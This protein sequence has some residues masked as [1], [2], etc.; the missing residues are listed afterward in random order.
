MVRK[1]RAVRLHRRA[2]ANAHT[3]DEWAAS[4]RQL[5]ALRGHDVWRAERDSKHFDGALLRAQLRRIRSARVGGRW[6]DLVEDV[7]EGLHRHL[8]ELTAP[9]LYGH[10]VGGTKYIVDEFFDEVQACIQ[11]LAQ[12]SLPETTDAERLHRFETAFQNFGRSAL[13]LSGGATLGFY[14]LGVARALWNNG[15]LPNIISGSSMGAMVAAAVC[16][17]TDNELAIFFDR[18]RD[19]DPKALA[20]LSL[21]EMIKHRALLDQELLRKAIFANFKDQTFADAYARTGRVLNITVSPT[22]ARQKPRVLNYRTAPRVLV[23]Q[24]CLA[25]SAVPGLFPPVTLMQRADSGE[26]CPYMPSETWMDGS[27]QHDLPKRRLSRLQNVNHFIVSQANPHV[28]PLHKATEGGGLVNKAAGLG[29]RLM[30][31]QSAQVLELARHATPGY[32][33]PLFENAQAF[34]GQDYGGDINIHPRFEPKLFTKM[35]SNLSPDELERFVLEGQRATWPNLSI[36]RNQTAVGRALEN[37]IAQLRRLLRDR[38]V[39]HRSP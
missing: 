23:A 21:S 20:V 33:G 29:G 22:R 19:V 18:P 39:E 16:T 26:E 36:I 7:Y 2:L 8:A 32:L 5:D 25:S 12:A 24:A 30:R 10:A 13:L 35:L 14:H 6:A 9:E 15:L 27:I 38:R 37:A 28:F 17:R 11:A 3:Y 34:L 31:A 4:A 1:S